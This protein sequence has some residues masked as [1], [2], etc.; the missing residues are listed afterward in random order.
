MTLAAWG[1]GGPQPCR[2]ASMYSF[3]IQSHGDRPAVFYSLLRNVSAEKNPRTDVIW[4]RFS[5][6][7]NRNKALLGTRVLLTQALEKQHKRSHFSLRYSTSFFSWCD[8]LI[9]IFLQLC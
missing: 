8:F 6:W 7:P 5:R 1:P 2:G 3:F 9:F 4:N